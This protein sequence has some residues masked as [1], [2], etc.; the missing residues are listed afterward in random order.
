[1]AGTPAVCR[2]GCVGGLRAVDVV[3]TDRI[4]VVRDAAKAY[5]EACVGFCELEQR[6]HR[7]AIVADSPPVLGRDVARFCGGI[8]LSR[9]AALIAGTPAETPAEHDLVRR[10]REAG[11]PVA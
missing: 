3:S 2:L 6:C 9:A 5:E 10:A 8:P 4:A 7:E 1:L 11:R